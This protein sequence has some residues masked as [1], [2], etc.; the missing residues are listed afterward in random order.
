MK[1]SDW[2]VEFLIRNGVTDAFGLPGVVVLELV[3]AME[4]RTPEFTPHLS[5]HE[6]GA[7]FAACGYAQT[8]G[9]LGV[10]YSTRGPG[11]LNMTTG[12]ADAY[13]DSIPTMFLT[14]HNYKDMNS[15]MRILNN[16]E[17]DTVEVV[18]SFTKFSSRI[19]DICQVKDIVKRAYVAATTGRKGP[20]FID[21]LSSVMKE[22]LTDDGYEL[23]IMPI[24]NAYKKEISA[25]CDDIVERISKAKHPII[26]AGNGV[27][28]S[29]TQAYVDD[30][31]S[32]AGIPILTSRTGQDIF[33]R[34]KMYYG[35]VGSH[36]ARYSHFILS[37]ADLI[38]ALGNRLSFPVNSKSFKPIVDN[39]TTLRVDVDDNE[40]ERPVPNSINYHFNLADLMPVLAKRKASY[41]DSKKWLEIC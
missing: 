14:A 26:L 35:Y 5:Y 6:Q 7:A 13:Y 37:K 27:I 32:K 1:A 15:K 10:A 41:E 22:D 24:D 25:A 34:S 19:D 17:M 3:Y 20:V 16:Q 4:R 33:P 39:C 2:I 31:A 21:I 12:I 30:F 11:L 29:D 23:E 28:Q 38:I 9:K 18:R 36:A 40:F 8:T